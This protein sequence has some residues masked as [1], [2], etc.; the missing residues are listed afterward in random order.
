M[1]PSLIECCEIVKVLDAGRVLLIFRSTVMLKAGGTK[2][3]PSLDSRVEL[4]SR[5]LCFEEE[6]ALPPLLGICE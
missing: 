6:K 3:L 2:G 1:N 5:P 4:C